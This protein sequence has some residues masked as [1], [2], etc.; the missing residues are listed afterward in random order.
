MLQFF[1]VGLLYAAYPEC[2]WSNAALAI[3]AALGLVSFAAML[4]VTFR[5]G[6][7]VRKRSKTH[8]DTGS[9]G[10]SLIELVIAIAIM[11]V[12]IGVLAP[13]FLKYTDRARRS[14]DLQTMASVKEAMDV[15]RVD[16]DLTLDERYW[17]GSQNHVFVAVFPKRLAGDSPTSVLFID[18]GADV[19]DLVESLA[20]LGI[21]TGSLIEKSTAS[22]WKNGYAVFFSRGLDEVYVLYNPT[23]A[24][25][26]YIGS[27]WNWPILDLQTGEPMVDDSG[28]RLKV[29]DLQTQRGL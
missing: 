19:S 18:R 24:Y 11:A 12:L 29:T 17:L 7:N 1:T 8:R 13:Q 21:D 28:R 20:S 25:P 6:A 15:L 10:F 16:G 4:V 27:V 23:D 9:G 26:G 2:G 3:S 22:V 14:V 5:D